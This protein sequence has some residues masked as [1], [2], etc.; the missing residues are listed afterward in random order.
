M[1]NKGEI[2]QIHYYNE[3]FQYSS[4][5]KTKYYLKHRFEQQNKLGLMGL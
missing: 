4:L 1:R 5:K 2:C 3:K